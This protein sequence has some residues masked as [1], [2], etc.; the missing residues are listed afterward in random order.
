METVIRETSKPSTSASVPSTASTSITDTVN[1][2][3][4]FKITGYSLSK[5]LGIGKYRASNTFTV[6]GH[7]WAIYF[8][9]DG[10][11][12]E[13]NATYVSLFIALASDG[14]DV[15][16]LFEL[17]LFDQS[18]RERHKVHTHFGR[19][20]DGGPYTLKYRGSMWGYKRFYKRSILENS[21]YLKDDCLL[22]NCSV[23][24]VRSHTERPKIYGIALPP[25]TLGLDLGKMLESGKGVDVTFEVNG[26]NFYAHRLILAAR[27]PVF[28]AQFYGPMKDQNT[29]WIKVEDIEPPVFKV[30]TFFYFCQVTF[31][32][33]LLLQV[34]YK[35]SYYLAVRICI[36]IIYLNLDIS[37]QI[38]N[39]QVSNFT[40]CL[41]SFLV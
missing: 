26:E 38:S 21:D 18:G 27:S 40:C 32:W 35:R 2:S 17:T 3:H 37:W 15:R 8:Y 20:M 9:P 36:F 13:D 34:I 19:M 11:S 4:Q 24:V 33:N 5:G 41:S 6:G 28:R 29:Q 16:A 25:S 7:E 30:C 1:S 22:V 14:T 23:G 12:P 10:K 31:W 39:L